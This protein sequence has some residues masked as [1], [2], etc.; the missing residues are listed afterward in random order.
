MKQILIL[1][2]LSLGKTQFIET[3]KTNNYWC[4]NLNA[5]NVLSMVSHKVGWDGIRSKEYYD[6]L[7]KFES[8]ANEYF[9]FENWYIHDMIQK[10]EQN[11]KV[12]IL[13]IHNCKEEIKQALYKDYTN[14]K[15]ILIVDQDIL[16]NA[17]HFTANYTHPDYNNHVL[18][19]L[20]ILGE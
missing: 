16:D 6:F 4:W 20:Q 15:G 9:D 12:Q 19:I 1:D 8:L 3:A 7:S 18:E 11:E 2:G 14:C 5:R 10:F 13:I 17:Y